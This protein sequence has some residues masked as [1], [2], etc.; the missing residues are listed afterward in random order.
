MVREN[1]MI[2]GATLCRSR[3]CSFFDGRVRAVGRRVYNN[4]IL[5]FTTA[6]AEDT[7][8][9]TDVHT[10]LRAS[11]LSR[12]GGFFFRRRR[13]SSVGGSAREGDDRGGQWT[14]GWAWP[15]RGPTP[16]ARP[17]TIPLPRPA[18]VA[19]CK[20]PGHRLFISGVSRSPPESDSGTLDE[21]TIL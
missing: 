10:S 3:A 6:V 13:S 12:R 21:N 20:S 5:K 9:T 14:A 15:T 19:R 18:T 4:N 11:R 2:R 8:T 1:T 17:D 7:T 16:A